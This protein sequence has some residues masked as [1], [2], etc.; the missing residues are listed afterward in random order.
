[1]E[2]NDVVW[3][4]WMKPVSSWSLCFDGKT[5]EHTCYQTISSSAKEVSTAE[6]QDDKVAAST[7]DEQ[8]QQ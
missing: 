6:R 8:G 4:M 3:D 5:K 2:T 1:M 7:G